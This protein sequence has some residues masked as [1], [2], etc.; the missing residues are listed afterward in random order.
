MQPT[1]VKQGVKGHYYRKL[2]ETYGTPALLID[3][4]MVRHQYLLLKSA[5]PDVHLYYAIK[6]LP[7]PKVIEVLAALGAGFEIASSGEINLLHRA[8]IAPRTTIHTHPIK[9][10]PDIRQA[11]RFGCTTFVIDNTEELLKFIPYKHR[12]G[13]LLRLSFQS[14]DAVVDLS[15]KFGCCPDDA[16]GLIHLA[17]RLGIHIK[18]LTFHA[19]SQ[20]TNPS[21]HVHAINVCNQIIRQ[22]RGLG[23][24]PMSM[25][26]IGGG[27]PVAYDSRIPDI[28]TFTAPIR[29]ALNQLP[30]NVRV[31]AEPGRF[32]VAPAGT[33]MM[34]IIG[35]AW[36]NDRLWYYLDDGIY[37]LFSGQV[38]DHAR[39]PMEIFS[40]SPKVYPSVLAGPTCDSIDV[41]VE[42]VM[43]P[44]LEIGE[45]VIGRQMGAYTAASATS[46]NSLPPAKV[47]V[48]DSRQTRS[49]ETG[50]ADIA[51]QTQN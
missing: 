14:S 18:G 3:C 24:A 2:A 21:M 43:L 36:R 48:I 6:A 35:K 15:R 22:S 20:C 10:D 45:I 4:R 49:L 16:P 7:H 46:F 34:S 28:E 13:L 51:G 12:V 30:P 9:R 40:T 29:Q 50:R 1:T 23:A 25:L 41:I 32:L 39:Y 42:D 8:R 37:G 26:D 19:G 44:E 47:V 33:A 5:L 17:A 31:A 38:F 11:L 27:F